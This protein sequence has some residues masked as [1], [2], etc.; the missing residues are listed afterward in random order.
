MLTI[1]REFWAHSDD[2]KKIKLC[3][4]L[5][6]TETTTHHNKQFRSQHKERY[7]READGGMLARRAK[8]IG[9]GIYELENGH[10]LR[11]NSK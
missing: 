4:C 1:L 6:Q 3:E 7:F 2:G 5:V 8:E 11:E 10:I 9:P